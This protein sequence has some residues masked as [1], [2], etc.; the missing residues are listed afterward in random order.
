MP[1]CTRSTRV[2]SRP[3]GSPPGM[4]LGDS[5]LRGVYRDPACRS[6]MRFDERVTGCSANQR[7]EVP[8]AF[9]PG[10]RST[11]GALINSGREILVA[12]PRA[13][14]CLNRELAG[15]KLDSVP[16]A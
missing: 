1:H 5:G 4:P 16:N 15:R 3:C 14:G 10:L 8:Q 12:L 6:A 11:P 7:G 13:E 2:T 9:S